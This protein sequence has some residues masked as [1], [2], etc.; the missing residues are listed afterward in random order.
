MATEFTLQRKDGKPFGSFEQVQARIRQLFPSVEFHWTTS[1]QEKIALAAKREI[2]FPPALKTVLADLPSLL[3]G[4][5][6][7]DGFHVT[8][9]LGHQEPVPCL[10]VT[11]RGIA[12]ELERCLAALEAD[13]GG[14]FKVSGAG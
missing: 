7:G 3:D 5:A 1:G 13:A 8:F 12:P 14:P 2:S 10:Y 9:G 11:P 6:E 4:V